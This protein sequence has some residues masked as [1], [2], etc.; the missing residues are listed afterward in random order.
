MPSLFFSS[1]WESA[2]RT[3]SRQSSLCSLSGGWYPTLKPQTHRGFTF[4]QIP[5]IKGIMAFRLDR[6]QQPEKNQIEQ[7][8]HKN[9]EIVLLDVHLNE[10]ERAHT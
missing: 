9:G 2:G 6:P 7:L 5:I 10:R 1:G 3:E 4:F 8:G